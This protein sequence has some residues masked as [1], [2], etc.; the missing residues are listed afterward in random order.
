MESSHP[1][2][3]A[4]RAIKDCLNALP[5]SMSRGQR[6]LEALSL[7]RSARLPVPDD[8]L[9]KI[10][11]CYRHF[12]EGK[13]VAGWTAVEHNR[14]APLTLGEA[15]G[16]SEI[17]GGDVAALKRKRLAMAGPRLVALFD[18]RRVT[19]LARTKEGYEVAA[20]E[21]GL[22]ASEIE[23]WVTKYLAVPRTKKS[24]P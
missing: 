16:V 24:L 6:A 3:T 18:G 19:R 14:P 1:M 23:D 8:V 7:Y 4:E 10:D 13:P 21:L 2:S 15:F 11:S 9:R 22:T 20:M 12:T 17:R 5:V